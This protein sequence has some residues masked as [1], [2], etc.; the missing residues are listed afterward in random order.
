MPITLNCP[1]CHK[2]FRV[3]DES[4]GGKVRCP[5]CGA[6]LAVPETLASANSLFDLPHVD[7]NPAEVTGSHRPIA[8][9]VLGSTQQV[10]GAYGAALPAPPSIKMPGPIGG[11]PGVAPNPPNPMRSH[12]PVAPQPGGFQPPRPSTLPM[13]TSPSTYQPPRPA[14]MPTQMPAP[15]PM[16]SPGQH[17]Q[18]GPS[19]GNQPWLPAPAPAKPAKR[20]NSAPEWLGSYRGLGSI[21]LALWLAMVPVIGLCVHLILAVTNP[22]GGFKD[23][24][25]FLGKEEW[26][27]WKESMALYCGIPLALA[28]LFVLLGRL[29][30]IS[31]PVLSGAR[32]LALL[33]FLFMLIA[34]GSIGILVAS[35]FKDLG[36]PPYVLP[37]APVVAI[38]AVLLTDIATLFF[39]GQAA[40]AVGRIETFRTVASVFLL[41]VLIPA[42]AIVTNQQLNVVQP[43]MDRWQTEGMAFS[44]GMPKELQ[45]KFFIAAGFVF[46]GLFLLLFRYSNSIG[47]ARYGI[48]NAMTK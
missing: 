23:G 1:K 18:S 24:P 14:Q 30:C 10:G 31:A 15:Q 37:A 25:G 38:A 45:T 20:P 47:S 39:I 48:R 21:Q 34:F 41:A 12:L 28:G 32:G 44:S 9:D 29:Q 43:L 36:L 13:P 4:I 11:A 6:I 40:S 46:G 16:P 5:S 35:Q 27:R 8:E 2:P 42:A 17:P 33:A 22:E 7:I 26:P 19:Q 3:R